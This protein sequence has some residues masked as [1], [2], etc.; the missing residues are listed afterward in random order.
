MFSIN[1]AGLYPC[2]NEDGE[3]E[4]KP[5]DDETETKPSAP[6]GGSDKQVDDDD[7]KL[8]VAQTGCTEEKAREA[9]KAENGDLINASELERKVTRCI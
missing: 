5:D 8:V 2:R 9:L 7:V 3:K 1:F 4:A 6:T